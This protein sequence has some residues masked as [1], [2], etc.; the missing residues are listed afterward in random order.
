MDFK[1]LWH[2]YVPDWK[3]LLRKGLPYVLV[4]V[5]AAATAI[6]ALGVQN[7]RHIYADINATKVELETHQQE[8]NT[9]LSQTKDLLD[10]L[11]AIES[12]TLLLMQQTES[13]KSEVADKI[14]E[15]KNTFESIENKE[16]QRWILPMQ[17]K[18]CSSSY[19]YR[20]HPVRGEANFHG[21]VD[22]AADRGTPIVASR[23]GTV[24]YAEYIENDAGYWVLIDHLDGFESAYMH[25]DKYIVTEGQFV[26]A[27]QLIGYCGASG[28]ATGNHLHFEIRKNNQTV[29]PA[30]YI[31]MY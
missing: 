14:E 24:K 2:K 5:F 23:S 22:L 9:I 21:G 6:A 17:Y 30:D 26:V 4:A 27:G 20:E 28:V 31:D 15:L 8:L 19:G 25:M 18:L 10:R 13:E 3:L 29:N 7:N 1:S 12:D 11:R 16:R